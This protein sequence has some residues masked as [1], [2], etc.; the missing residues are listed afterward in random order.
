MSTHIFNIK[1]AAL[2]GVNEAII[3]QNISFWQAKNEANENNFYDGKYWVYNSVKAFE[4]LFPYW[5]KGQLNRILKNLEDKNAIDVSNY[6][7]V[8]YDRTKWYSLN[9]QLHLLIT[10]NGIAVIEK[11]IPDSKT[12]SKTDKIQKEIELPRFVDRELWNDFMEIR[13]QKKAV[14]SDRAMKM[15]INDLDKFE[16]SAPGSAN[17]AIEESIKNSWKGLFAPKKGPFNY[18]DLPSREIQGNLLYLD[19][20]NCVIYDSA[21]KRSYDYDLSPGGGISA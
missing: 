17:K 8:S 6:N 15:L 12:D 9:Q 16:R 5:S 20:A 7:K 21:G 18:K 4:Q 3:L 1:V 19:Y 14:Q 11:P 13:I 10:G 2:Y